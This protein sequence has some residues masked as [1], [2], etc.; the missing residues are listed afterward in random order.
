MLK[1]LSKG[2]HVQQLTTITCNTFLRKNYVSYRWLHLPLNALAQNMFSRDVKRLSFRCQTFKFSRPTLKFY[3]WLYFSTRLKGKM[4]IRKASHLQ[5]FAKLSE[6]T[7]TGLFFLR[8]WAKI[9]VQFQK[10]LSTTLL[11]LINYSCSSYPTRASYPGQVDGFRNPM[12]NE[13]KTRPCLKTRIW[14]DF[15]HGYKFSK[16][17]YRQSNKNKWR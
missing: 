17:A 13:L 11:K 5:R 7:Q 9:R 12:K 8:S 6:R 2:L 16:S 4:I 1:Q 10:S 15:K 3:F 14:N